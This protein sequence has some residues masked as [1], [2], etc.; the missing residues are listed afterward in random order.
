MA[1][2]PRVGGLLWRV[3]RDALGPARYVS[4]LF[5]WWPPLVAVLTAVLALVGLSLPD[6][7]RLSAAWWV[8]ILFGVLAFLFA[9]S[10]YRLHSTLNP[11]FPLHALTVGN[12][13]YADLENRPEPGDTTRVVALPVSYV[14]REPERRAVLEFEL[15]WSRSV[16][17]QVL[18]PYKL[19]PFKGKPFLESPL[20]VEPESIVQAPGDIESFAFYAS[21]SWL[22]EFGE[23]MEV[24]INKDHVLI[25]RVTDRVTGAV[26]E[27]PVSGRPLQ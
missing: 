27:R 22:F 5:R 2:F 21:E 1:D 6:H 3:I 15:W 19:S 13:W 10:A 16:K 24:Q 23:L 20:T 9:G 17:G 14:N 8:A 26:T 7:L 25:L 4:T 18:G 11:G 12:L